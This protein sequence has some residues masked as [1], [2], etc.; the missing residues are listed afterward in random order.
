MLDCLDFVPLP[1][2][3]LHMLS[4][5]SPASGRFC[6]GVASDAELGA[7]IGRYVGEARSARPTEENVGTETKGAYID[8]EIDVGKKFNIFILSGEERA[9]AVEGVEKRKERATAAR[10]CRHQKRKERATAAIGT[11]K[12]KRP[13]KG[14]HGPPRERTPSV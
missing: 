12:K 5:T 7:E 13:R 10:I 2:L 1:C 4:G 6:A 11:K 9:T 3:S 8:A 14:H